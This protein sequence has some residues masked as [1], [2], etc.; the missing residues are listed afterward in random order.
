MSKAFERVNHSRLLKKLQSFNVNPCIIKLLE[1]AFRNSTASV[2]YNSFSKKRTIRR[3][4]RQGEVL[5]AFVFSVYIYILFC[6]K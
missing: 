2:F 6:L 5:S 3:G 4:C 1:N